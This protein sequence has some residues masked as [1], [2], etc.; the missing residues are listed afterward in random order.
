[1][2]DVAGVAPGNALVD[3]VRV[4]ARQ[5][6]RSQGPHQLQ[7]DHGDPQ[8]RVGVEERAQQSDQHGRSP[9]KDAS[10]DSGT[11]ISIR[12][13][14]RGSGKYLVYSSG[15]RS[16]DLDRPSRQAKIAQTSW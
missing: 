13:T 4:Q 14:I 2:D 8:R 5:V 10:A 9:L 12:M 15:W 6:E 1:G 7:R 11:G 3:D 16:A